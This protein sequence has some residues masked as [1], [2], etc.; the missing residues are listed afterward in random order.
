MTGFKGSPKNPIASHDVFV[1]MGIRKGK[2][3]Q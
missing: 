1:K 2:G 3:I